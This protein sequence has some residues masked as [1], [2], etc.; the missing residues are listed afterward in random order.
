VT[1]PDDVATGGAE[2]AT[3]GPGDRPVDPT[4]VRTADLPPTPVRDRT[5]PATAWVEAPAALLALGADIG[6]PVVAYKRRIGPW[7]LWRAGPPTKGD[8]RYMAVAADDPGV[9]FTFRLLP[10]GSGEGE[11]PDRVVHHRFRAWKEALRD[12]PPE[13]GG[14]PS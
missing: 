10:D 2:G 5:I 9:H 3:E 7:L 12:T 6:H 1:N 14:G 13:P 11:G 4:P 8:A